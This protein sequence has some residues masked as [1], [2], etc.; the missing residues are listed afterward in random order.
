MD[1]KISCISEKSGD[2]LMSSPESALRDA[3]NSLAQE[4]A[5]CAKCIRLRT[6]NS[7]VGDRFVAAQFAETL[8]D[9]CLLS[10]ASP[11]EVN[12]LANIFSQDFESGLGAGETPIVVNWGFSRLKKIS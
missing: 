2:A 4:T 5:I 8:E 10:S 9:R 6:P 7:A 12:A 11:I 3:I 1:D